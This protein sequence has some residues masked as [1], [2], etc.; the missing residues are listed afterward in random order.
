MQRIITATTLSCLS[1]LSLQGYAPQQP[2]M[3][4]T[5]EQLRNI[6]E[7][8]VTDMLQPNHDTP[9]AKQLVVAIQ[10]AV[11]NAHGS[12]FGVSANYDAVQK[13]IRTATVQQLASMARAYAAAKKVVS[14]HGQNVV[15]TEVKDD[16]NHLINNT[17][18]LSG[19]FKHHAPGKNLN[20]R[21]REILIAT[22]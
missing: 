1:L 5:N 19:I 15:E 7:N 14:E 17:T 4:K 10:L 22:L 6:T 9:E 18:Y 21:V 13:T 12:W 8:T 16:L 20:D 3:I 11:Y 2:D